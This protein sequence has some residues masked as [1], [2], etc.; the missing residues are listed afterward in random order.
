MS[1]SLVSRRA[2]TS[3]SAVLAAGGRPVLA[4]PRPSLDEAAGAGGDGLR[5]VGG[6]DVR[7]ERG[8]IS[9][10]TTPQ[11]CRCSGQV[12]VRRADGSVRIADEQLDAGLL[13][14]ALQAVAQ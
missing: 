4:A 8:P 11:T 13:D 14:R 9:L 6:A 1:R 2:V 12:T 3:D 7:V 10:L 5:G